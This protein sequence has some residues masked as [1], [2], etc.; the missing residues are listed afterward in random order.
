MRQ[1][2]NY[3]VEET[4]IGSGGMGRVLRGKRISDGHPVALKEIL[5]DFVA[6]LEFRSRIEGEINF[7][8]TLNH[9]NVVKVFDSF[10]ANDNMYI[11]MELVEG[12]NIE[13]MVTKYG[14]MPW[15]VAAKYM[16]SMLSTLQYVHQR[17]IVHRDIKP[18]NIMITPSGQIRLL[19]FGVAKDVSE[20]N[21]YGTVIGTIIGTDGY[22]SPEQAQGMSIDKRSDIYSL[23][24]VFFYMLTGQHAIVKR[25]ADHA[26]KQ[27]IVYDEF[28]K[29]ADRIPQI[30]PFVDGIIAGAVEKNMMN[31]Y[32]SCNDFLNRIQSA[33]NQQISNQRSRYQSGN[34]GGQQESHNVTVSVGRLNCDMIVYPN[35]PNVSRH[36]L[37]V[38]LSRANGIESLVFK[39]CSSN[40]TVFNGVK[41]TNGGEFRVARGSNAV[42]YLAGDSSAMLDMQGLNRLID[43]KINSFSNK[44]SFN[45]GFETDANSRNNGNMP[46]GNFSRG[47][48]NF[49]G[50]SNSLNNS[51]HHNSE[52]YNQQKQE[53]RQPFV[54]Y[55]GTDT[56]TTWGGALKNCFRKYATFS[57][58]ASKAEFWWFALTAF[59]V[60]CVAF[61]IFA[62][63]YV[64]EE[65]DVIIAA[66][67]LI[68]LWEVVTFLPSLALYMRRLHDI[69]KGVGAFFL[70]IFVPPYALVLMLKRG[71][72]GVNSYGMPPGME[73]NNQ[74]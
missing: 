52:G 25:N 56:S 41:Y 18:S 71:D 2:G 1:I 29:V 17:G 47:N 27:H 23:G 70:S 50:N 42:I 4:P 74:Y 46:D 62:F 32:A 16:C 34:G 63:G 10:E 37:D 53:I 11:V 5:P 40:G 20:R 28:P 13:Q 33:G 14:P 39:D 69:D 44:D 8:K 49:Q 55:S 57:G 51:Y 21:Q 65:D 6:D 61:A 7:L 68:G 24:C 54:L 60:F 36:H 72:V 73:N 43:S 58:R 3:I 64:E 12:M 19:D 59:L 67:V 66:G 22:M 26:T 30:P 9:E 48:A 38:S 35:N 45:P 15:P 31:R